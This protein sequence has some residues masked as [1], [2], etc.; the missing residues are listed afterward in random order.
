MRNLTKYFRDVFFRDRLILISLGL[1]LILNIILWIMLVGKF[2]LSKEP[3]PLHF[4]IVSG[5]DFLGESRQLFELPASGVVIMLANFWLARTV[6]RTEKLFG[7]FLVGAAVA[8]QLLLLLGG[9][10]LLVLNS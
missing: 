5:I 10:A 2:G 8:V 4:N 3:V 1:S 7:Y 9:T 6:Y